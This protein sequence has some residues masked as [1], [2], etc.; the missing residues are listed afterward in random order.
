[1]HR[2]ARVFP[3]TDCQGG[4][5]SAPLRHSPDY[6]HSSGNER[7]DIGSA[8]IDDAVQAQRHRASRV[9]NDFMGLA[10]AQVH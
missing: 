2:W 5:S 8:E 3:K 9:V 1:M 7:V 6:P 4:D 10:A